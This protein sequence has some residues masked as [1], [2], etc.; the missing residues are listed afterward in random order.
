[1]S[2]DQ[3]VQSSVPQTRYGDNSESEWLD[4]DLEEWLNAEHF[5]PL[6][7]TRDSPSVPVGFPKHSQ[8]DDSTREKCIRHQKLPPIAIV[9]D[10]SIVVGNL[11]I[12]FC[13]QS[14]VQT[15]S[16]Q[17]PYKRSTQ[18]IVCDLEKPKMNQAYENKNQGTLIAHEE[19]PQ[20]SG[21]RIKQGQSLKSIL[22]RSVVAHL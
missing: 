5:P 8:P 22:G 11:P 16:H 7:S 6:S 14:Q 9:D 19:D 20:L 2:H 1:M 13:W 21:G 3:K 18:Q 15:D 12:N 17:S 4:V 10:N